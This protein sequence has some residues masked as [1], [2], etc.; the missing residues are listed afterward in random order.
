MT[1]QDADAAL[2]SLLQS[3]GI[4]AIAVSAD[5]LREGAGNGAQAV[6]VTPGPTDDL[7]PALAADGFG[8]VLQAVPLDGGVVWRVDDPVDGMSMLA[9]SDEARAQVLAALAADLRGELDALRGAAEAQRIAAIRVLRGLEAERDAG[10]RRL[11]AEP[12]DQALSRGVEQM[13]RL[14]LPLQSSLE[15]HS[16]LD[17]AP[18]VAPARTWVARGRHRIDRWTTPRLGV[19]YQHAPQPLRVAQRTLTITPPDPA[20]RISIVTPSYNQGH[21]IE[22]TLRSVLDQDYPELEYVV[23]DGGSTDD[24]AAVVR[25]YEDRLARFV[26]APDD[27]QAD[28]I[29]RGFEGTTGEIMAYLNSDDLL[30]P[31]SLAF[32]ARYLADHPDV[33]AVYGQRVIVDEADHAIGAWVTPPHDDD[34]LGLSNVVPQETLYWRRSAWDRVGGMDASFQFALDWDFLVRLRD[35]GARIV[36]V[37]RYLGAFRAHGQQKSQAEL[38]V[39]DAESDRLRERVH[40]RPMSWEEATAR[41]R[42]YLRRHVVHHT[43]H[44]VAARLPLPRTDVSFRD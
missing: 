6:L 22:A 3:A 21:F 13:T 10:R 39:G 23:Q 26:S 9:V 4:S 43:L 8:L 14:L 31:G 17:A 1:S 32:A 19:F 27:G 5:E 20:P 2:Q 25:R 44:R 34:M 28:A 12:G 41:M 38:S 37:N 16:P 29:N 33:D 18:L 24:T 42:P 30:L 15:A 11:D 40:G 36:R 7:L 35:S